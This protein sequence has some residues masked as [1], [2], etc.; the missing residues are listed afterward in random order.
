MCKTGDTNA[1]AAPNWIMG[2]A[3]TEV[4]V[5]AASTATTEQ[6]MIL[7]KGVLRTSAGGTFIPQFKYSAAPGGAP[8]VRRNSY[9]RLT[10]VGVNTTAS[11]GTWA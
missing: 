10:P 7:I 6:I 5:K 9:F 2:L 8:T 1:L 3:A 4:V 11:F